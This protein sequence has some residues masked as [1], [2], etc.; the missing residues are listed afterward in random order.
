M[1]PILLEMTA[2]GSYAEKTTVPFSDL[3]Q[4]LF[5]IS[6]ETGAGKTMIFDAIAFALYGRASGNDRDP[7]RMHC[8]RV[9][10][11][12]DTVVRLVFSQ[13]GREYTVERTL[14]FTKKRGMEEN[15]GDVKQSAVLKEADGTVLEGQQKVNDRCTELLGMNVEQFRKIV[16]LAQ[17]EFREFLKADSDKKNEIL[18]RLFDNSAFTRYQNLLNGAKNLLA[19]QRRENQTR[20]ANLISEGF[21]ADQVPEEERILFHPENPEFLKNLESLVSE[22]GNRLHE[23]EKKRNAIRKELEEMNTLRGAAKGDNDNLDEL[24]SRRTHLKALLSREAEIA[25]LDETARTVAAVLH[26]VKPAIDARERAES[27][28]EKKRKEIRELEGLAERYG[29]AY[30]EARKITEG[31]AETKAQAEK[32]GNELHSLTKQLPEY[33]SLK[34]QTDERNTAGRAEKAARDLREEAE[35]RQQLL[36]AEQTENG[37][38]LEALKEAE[39]DVKDCAEK[40]ETARKALEML[41]GKGGITDTIRSVQEAEACFSA[42]Q[43]RLG[44]LSRKARDAEERH[45]NLYQRFVSGQAGLLADTLRR[46]I[47]ASGSAACPVC[48]TVHTK[49]DPARFAC[50]P[51]GTP[52]Q[53]EVGEAKEAFDRAENERREQEK[54]VQETQRGIENSKNALLRKADALFPGCTWEKLSAASFLTDANRT[55]REKADTAGNELKQA[56]EKQKTRDELLKKQEENQKTLTETAETID[57]SRQEEKRYHDAYVSADS[58]IAQLK[59][60]LSYESEE[61]AAARIRELKKQQQALQGEI[62]AH[63][64]A[65]SEAKQKL[66]TAKG[67]LDGKRKEIPSLE[68]DLDTARQ[69]TEKT[70]AENGFT[71][72]D[73]ALAVLAPVR[74]GDGE[75]WIREQNEAIRDY[76]NDCKN[77]REQILALEGKT[78]GKNHTDLRELDAQISA[79]GEEWKN[80]DDAFTAENNR[81]IHHRKIRDKAIEYKRALASTDGAWQRLNALGTLAAGSAGDGGKL[82]FDRYVMGTVFREILEM[83]NRRIDVMSGGRFELVHKTE[84]DRK[85]TK[86]GL[87]IE[88]RDTFTD[89]ARP[90]SLLSGGEGFY[91]SLSLALGLSDVVQHHAG[92]KK[93]DALFIDEGFGTLSPDVL[94]KAMEVLNQ[95]ATGNRLVG[96]ISHV[97]KLDESIPQKIRVTGGERGS[98]VRMELS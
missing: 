89:K 82:S 92:G 58:A 35:A 55:F 64:R 20:L 44:D 10:P 72:A 40:E 36:T 65:E 34:E 19:E 79:K 32:L 81:F 80:A 53:A 43:E 11:A 42:E 98:R 52:R 67:G 77:T 83:A 22:D 93:L 60:A 46:E 3:R 38:L 45:H 54:L 41:T 57:K 33:Q 84:S 26:T 18:G 70:L 23:L 29:K 94:D 69:E 9:S 39:R 12:V 91:A 8:D 71:N 75:K 28:L 51:E 21:P 96:I 15:Y 31:D 62:E 66:D 7:L 27:A 1:K 16:M 87:E 78:E 14:H 17:G 25:R 5:L 4:G 2:F 74:D 85:N 13:N 61:A 88:V 30:E 68:T 50:M 86:A 47:E 6:G 95:L 97:D 56:R 73:A 49:A 76:H 24:A 59:K 63:L 48:G 37:K 90:S